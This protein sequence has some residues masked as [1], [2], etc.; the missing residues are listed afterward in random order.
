MKHFQIIWIIKVGSF[1]RLKKFYS[2]A[3]CG[4]WFYNK[5]RKIPR[6]LVSRPKKKKEKMRGGGRGRNENRNFIGAVNTQGQRVWHLNKKYGFWP[7]VGH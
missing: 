6:A 4:H 2:V 7:G 1:E 5:N 3:E